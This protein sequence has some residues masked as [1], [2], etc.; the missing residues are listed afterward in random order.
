MK[1]ILKEAE[2]QQSLHQGGFVKNVK[3]LEVNISLKALN[4]H[5][6]EITFNPDEGF[7]RDLPVAPLAFKELDDYF[8]YL[9]LFEVNGKSDILY[10]VSKEEHQ[11]AKKNTEIAI[12]SE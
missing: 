2:L 4:K 11:K 5:E 6:L 7:K 8:V 12:C 10:I 3:G 9:P 1:V